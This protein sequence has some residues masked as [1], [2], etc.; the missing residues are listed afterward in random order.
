VVLGILLGALA[1]QLML[2]GLAEL[3][4]ITMQAH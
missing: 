4:T 3:G 2:N 1:V